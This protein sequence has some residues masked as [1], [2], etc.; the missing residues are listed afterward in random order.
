MKKRTLLAF[1]LLAASGIIAPAG[2]T[3]LRVGFS[4]E[5]SAHQLV[6]DS[7]GS[8]RGSIRMMAYSFTDPTVMQALMAAKKRGVDVEI[9]IDE[10]GNHSKA[11]KAAMNLMVNSG[12]PLRTDSDFKIQHDKVIIIDGKSVETGSYNY[13]ASANKSNSEN[14]ILI[15][16]DPALA[17]QYLAHWQDRWNRGRDYA[18]SY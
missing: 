12:I 15:D 7:I 11:S 6:L 5:G 10:K 13:T 3:T 4:P 2:A 1:I 18:S 16:D 17:R 14:A 9:V 8:A